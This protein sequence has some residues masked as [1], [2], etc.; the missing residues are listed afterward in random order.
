MSSTYIPSLP[1]ISLK[2]SGS[3]EVCQGRGI[4]PVL[5]S[6]QK[7]NGKITKASIYRFNPWSP[8]LIS[9]R[10][11]LYC[12]VLLPD[13]IRL[14]YIHYREKPG[15]VKRFPGSVVKNSL[16]KK[17]GQKKPLVILLK[18]KK[19]IRKHKEAHIQTLKVTHE[20]KF[21]VQLDAVGCR[22]GYQMKSIGGSLHVF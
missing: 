21:P 14:Q 20:N 13:W 12:V 3:T 8:I 2:K 4:A 6:D 15:E 18:V 22:L 10:K 9:H 17:D 1:D 16:R 19:Q 11:R 5:D 7:A